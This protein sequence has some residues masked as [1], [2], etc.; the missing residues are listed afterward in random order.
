MTS[1]ELIDHTQELECWRLPQQQH[2]ARQLAPA[3]QTEHAG[4]PAV[5]HRARLLVELSAE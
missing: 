3:R 2:G 5:E 4:P 1:L